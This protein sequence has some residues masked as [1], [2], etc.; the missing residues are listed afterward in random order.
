MSRFLH[1]SRLCFRHFFA[2]S[3]LRPRS[4][5]RFST[6]RQFSS[7]SAKY[8][9]RPRSRILLATAPLPPAAFVVLSQGDNDDGKTGEERMLKQSRAEI[10]EHVPSVIENSTRWRRRIYFVVDLY[11][12]EPICT[13]LRFLHL[14]VIFVP[15]ILT[16]PMVW[17]GRRIP[18]RDNERSGTLWW[19]GY[20]VWSMQKAGA[21][22]IKVSLSI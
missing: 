14:F 17:I 18:E 6:W 11:I 5:P 10:D 22:F 15:V 9:I 12:W 21:A 7:P 16:V 2:S 4:I 1:T 8:R 13:S 20:L 3:T 19:Y